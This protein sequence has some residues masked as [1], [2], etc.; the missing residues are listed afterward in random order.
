MRYY[1]QTPLFILPMHVIP[2]PT[3]CKCANK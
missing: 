1:V 3:I 2:A